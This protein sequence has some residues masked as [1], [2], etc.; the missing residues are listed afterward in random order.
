MRWPTLSAGAWK[1]LISILALAFAANLAAEIWYAPRTLSPDAGGTLGIQYHELQQ[2]GRSRFVID[3]IAANSPLNAVGARTGDLWYPDR[4]YDAWRRLE[5]HESIG[6]TLVNEGTA[7][8]VTVETVPDGV[9]VAVGL[10]VES[11]ILGFVVMC[12]ALLVGFRQPNGLAFRALALALI[13]WMLVRPLPTY[14]ILPAGPAFLVQHLLWGPVYVF[15]AVALLAFFFNFPDDQPRDTA[16]KRRLLRYFM[17]PVGLIWA[18]MLALSTARACGYYAPMHAVVVASSAVSFTLLSLIVMVSN[19][20]NSE[21]NLRERHL[22]VLAAFSLTSFVPAIVTVLLLV[23]ADWRSLQVLTWFPRTMGMASALIFAYAA[24]RHRVVGIGFVVNRALV[25]GAAS[26]GILVSFG[27]LEWLAHG[28]LASSGHEK[29]AFVDAGI[30][31]AIILVFHRLRHTGEEWVEQLF[32]HAWH[33]KE[34]ALRRFID[35]APHITRP[36]ALIQS[37]ATALDQ[38]TD[39]AG[40]AIYRRAQAGDY[41][42]LAAT[43]GAAPQRVDA[44]DPLAVSMR[45]SQ[46]VVHNTD[47]ATLLPGCIALPSLHHGVLDGFVLLGA[48]SGGE[49]YRPDEVKVLGTAAHQV[50]LDLRALRMEQLGSEN[51]HLVTENRNLTREN[52]RLER[53]S[54]RLAVVKER[55]ESEKQG[56]EAEK[57]GLLARND[58]LVA[59]LLGRGVNLGRAGDPL[60]ASGHDT[61]EPGGQPRVR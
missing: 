57:V 29:N 7:R 15:A 27:L 6:L 4:A 22:W 56:Y 33:V 5:A 47:T 17:P 40:H 32:F 46:S 19:W 23:K 60:L 18:A 39:D 59:A 45:A 12:L 34:A 10:Y 8:H 36:D 11:W 37:F 21:G 42:L 44:D 43:L 55:L 54:K 31:L 20:R 51:Q 53:E 49:T 35:E 52:D 3:E 50:G 58:E 61:T 25:Y 1:V 48:K 30:A 16:T 26:A 24:L 41:K 9:P 14:T 2:L 38:F 13:F 28:L